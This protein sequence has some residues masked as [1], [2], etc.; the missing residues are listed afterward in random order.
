MLH[1][2]RA[3]ALRGSWRAQSRAPG[4]VGDDRRSVRTENPNEPE[5]SAKPTETKR[6]RAQPKTE[7]TRERRTI[8]QTCGPLNTERTQEIA[9]FQQLR[10][11]N[12]AQLTS[13]TAPW[14]GMDGRAEQAA[15]PKLAGWNQP[16]S[17]ALPSRRQPKGWCPATAEIEV[18]PS[19]LVR[20][21]DLANILWRPSRLTLA[22]LRP[23]IN[24]QPRPRDSATRSVAR[25]SRRESR[26]A[27]RGRRRR[28]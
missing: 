12:G 4:C 11:S 15:D 8:T 20:T 25:R 21:V 16:R 17:R 7:R 5:R 23:R 9:A 3:G 26:A 2:Q 24:D 13:T 22:F 18:R 14:G 27:R 19:R 28:P 1:E 10:F 6:T